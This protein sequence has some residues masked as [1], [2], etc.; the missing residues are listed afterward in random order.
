MGAK[1]ITLSGID[2]SGKST[3]IILIEKYYKKINYQCTYLWTRGG[4]TPGIEAIKSLLRRVAGK[5]LPPS[6]HSA[7]RDRMF[8]KGWVQQTW[9][10]LSILDLLRIY[11]IKIRWELWRGRVV[12]CDRY[13]WDTLID[14][15]IM[16]P[17]VK[18]ESWILWRV[19]VWLSPKP[20]AEFLL[21]IPVELS[22]KRCS[23][24][25]DPFPDTKEHRDLRYRLYDEMSNTRNK[26]L[27]VDATKFKDIVFSQIKDKI[28]SL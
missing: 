10:I 26:W 20:H 28:L 27:V 21:M 6:G 9:I 18:I 13:L 11:S 15:R 23:Q 19:L 12:I 2:G 5:K 24:K 16:F 1:L 22:E 8:K 17:H 4:S 7:K 25:F 3:Q 14:F